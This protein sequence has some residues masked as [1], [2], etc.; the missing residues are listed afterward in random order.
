MHKA[1]YLNILTH[2]QSTKNRPL[3]SQ[4][5][6]NEVRQLV[7][8]GTHNANTGLSLDV[9][10]VRLEK[11]ADGKGIDVGILIYLEAEQAA[12]SN[13]TN[14]ASSELKEILI[15]SFKQP[16]PSGLAVTLYK[17]EENSNAV[18]ELRDESEGFNN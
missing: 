4:L 18:D 6:L 10:R 12:A 2:V 8:E 5:A 11:T 15:N 16:T 14:F 3:D 17:I 7:R 9:K 13:F 1:I